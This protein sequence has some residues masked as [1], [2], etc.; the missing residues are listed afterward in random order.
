MSIIQNFPLFNIVMCLMSGVISSILN[1]RYAKRLSL[2]LIG[3]A[4]VMNA[5][6]LWYVS[7]YGQY[8]YMMG[9]FPAP[10]GN[11]I[12]VGSLEALL[13]VFFC[14][15]MFLSVLG[16]EHYIDLEVEETKEN[17]YFTMICLMLASLLAL[18]Y[19]N[20]MFTAY[21]F[22]EI[23]TI[24]AGALIMSRNTG[25]TLVAATKY[26]IMSLV[27]SGFL[28]LGLS[29]L[30]SVTGHL[31]MVNMHEQIVRLSKS[32][33]Y[34]IPLTVS[35]ALMSVG[36]A[37]K[38]ALFPFHTWL[39]D[40]YSYSTPASAAILS[41]LVSKGYIFLLFKIFYRVFGFDFVLDHKVTNLLFAFGIAGMMVGSI[42]AIYQHD[43]RRLIAFSSVAQ[44]GYIYMGIG[45]AVP[46]GTVAAVFHIMSHAASK[47]MLFIAARGLSDASGDSKDFVDLK[48]SGFRNK[49]AGVGFGVGAFSMVGIPLFAGFTSKVYF[50]EAALRANGGKLVVAMVALAISTILNAVYFIRALITLYTPKNDGDLRA[51]EREKG[52]AGAGK[53][54]PISSAVA[55]I[56]F[57]LLNIFLG[58]WS[59]S[60]ERAIETGLSTFG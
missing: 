36:L 52:S 23:N 54:L 28:L 26:M 50:A 56:C 34:E 38:S 19:T 31:L 14:A 42:V 25:H 8:T 44:I 15:I 46:M 35:M 40:S 47:S 16:G 27:G 41:S 55:L 20:D 17:L 37:V 3:M 12:R 48:G 59:Y 53:W 32:G 57:I 4:G 39:A 1:G 22:V 13:A 5:F 6:V 2:T 60:I 30:Y 58:T 33:E 7:K 24:A 18:I 9:H 21:V 45:L 43:I 51:A 10:W 11:E 29:M 49:L